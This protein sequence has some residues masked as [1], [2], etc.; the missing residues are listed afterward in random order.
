MEN[1]DQIEQL[2]LTKSFEEL[3][4]NEK[5]IV[6][7]L[8]SEEEYGQMRA[9][10]AD[11]KL[12]KNHVSID[13]P[14]N[15]KSTAMNAFS[16]QHAAVSKTWA[17]RLSLVLFPAG[18]SF[19]QKPGFQMAFASIAIVFGI[20]IVGNINKDLVQDGSIAKL[21]EKVQPNSGIDVPKTEKHKEDVVS[22]D[23]E[24]L[25]AD[26]VETSGGLKDILFEST[27]EKASV[28]DAAKHASSGYISDKMNSTTPASSYDSPDDG[29]MSAITRSELLKDKKVTT[30]A[31]DEEVV[32]AEPGNVMNAFVISQEPDL[33]DLLSAAY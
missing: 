25:L 11:A 3:S 8:Y 21:E 27:D 2:M 16:T 13:L 12:Y 22:E 19:I 14:V 33:L 26:E 7:Q 17:E 6:S 20:W 4:D 31:M 30:I 15:H 32:G 18:K 1:F 10:I 29:L 24:E 9:M 23:K 28:K 5:G